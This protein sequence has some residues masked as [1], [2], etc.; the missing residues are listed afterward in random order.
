[1]SPDTRE[2]WLARVPPM[3]REMAGRAYDGTGG[4]AEAVRVNCLACAGWQR[5][6]IT[7]CTVRKCPLWHYRPYQGPIGASEALLAP[8]AGSESIPGGRAP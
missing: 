2:A 5:A 8:L 7:A 3:Y 1:M 6:E 4:R